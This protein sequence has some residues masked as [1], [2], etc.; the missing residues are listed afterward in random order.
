MEIDYQT[1]AQIFAPELYYKKTQ[2]LFENTY[3]EDLGGYFWRLLPSSVRWADVCVQY[4]LFFIQQRWVST[5]IF[6]RFSGK[7]PGEHP[8]D[9][10]PIFLYLKDGNPI[11]IVFDI[12]HYEAIGA[13]NSPSP[14][15]S[16]DEPPKLRIRHFYRG[17]VPLKD[18]SEY[19]PLY[20]GL[21]PVSEERIKEWWNGFTV[22]GIND[23]R[24][25]LVIRDKL[26]NPFKRITTF[27][28]HSS[29]LGFLFDR[30]FGIAKEYQVLDL[31]RDTDIIVSKV[32]DQIGEKLK[33]FSHKEI[34][35]VTDFVKQNL[36]QDLAIPEYLSLRVHKK[37][38]SI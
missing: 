13:I 9:Y 6:D 1:I 22:A 16:Q 32:E 37:F 8:N 24:A 34:V 25:K 30:I 3:P 21:L 31:P 10:V 19:T 2:D 38:Y 7:F 29:K 5:T 20:T 35:E 12:C 27:R 26:T 23:E 4:I 28:D 17:I 33:Y 36:F 15:F 18:E 14:F 11:R